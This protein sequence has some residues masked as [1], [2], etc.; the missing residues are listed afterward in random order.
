MLKRPATLS[1]PAS[2]GRREEV[3]QTTVVPA[4]SASAPGGYREEATQTI[5]LPAVLSS[6]QPIGYSE[7]TTQKLIRPTHGSGS[8][9]P[10]KPGKPTRRTQDGAGRG[11]RSVV[12]VAASA[13][14]SAAGGPARGRP[15]P[16]TYTEEATMKLTPRRRRVSGDGL[17][18]ELT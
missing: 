15:E 12:A 9:K 6:L 1:A 14:Q 7:E 16:G 8:G 17:L 5:I 3:T 4:L 11:G 2:G 13:E 10:A 18:E